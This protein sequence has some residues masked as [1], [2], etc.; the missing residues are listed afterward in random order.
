M[1]KLIAMVVVTVFLLSIVPMAFAER[2]RSSE[3]NRLEVEREDENEVEYETESE[4]SDDDSLD[5]SRVKVKERVRIKKNEYLKAREEFAQLKM[6]V[7]EG[8]IEADQTRTKLRSC[9]DV[10]VDDC[11]NAKEKY[12]EHISEVVHLVITKLEEIR[13]NLQ[14]LETADETAGA[15]AKIDSLISELNSGLEA[16]KIAATKEEYKTAL[17]KLKDSV[18]KAQEYIRTF[19]PQAF[20]YRLGGV[21]VKAERLTAK[22]EKLLQKAQ[23]RG[24]DATKA[25][26]LVESFKKTVGEAK[27]KFEEAKK[28]F[29]QNKLED[30]KAT[31]RE[32]HQ[33]LKK[34]HETLKQIHAALKA[35]GTE[36]SELL[37][38]AVPVA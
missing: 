18:K 35:S 21:L 13:A 2:G 26:P 4:D 25:K 17:L 23:E 12:N 24:R 14:S 33:L 15:I 22:L 9:A 28:L 19:V 8:K 10:T 29:S 34:A 27:Q 31:M 32:A 16:V 36:T 6:K 3:R 7:R 38:T 1:K 20:N 30:A 5:D 37:E 11:R